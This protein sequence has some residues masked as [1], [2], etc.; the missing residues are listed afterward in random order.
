MT[1]SEML[2]QE[3]LDLMTDNDVI[4]ADNAE[5]MKE[6]TD[7]I[8]RE[9]TYLEHL[10]ALQKQAVTTP[11][12]WNG[13]NVI[14]QGATSAGKTLTAEFAMAYQIYCRQKKVLYLVPLKTLTSEKL[15]DFKADFNGLRI[16]SSS[17]DYQEHDY[18]LIHGDY[19]IGILVYEKFF[20]LLAQN[21]K[22]FLRD[23]ELVVVDELH[24]L[25]DIDRGPKLEFSIEKLRYAYGDS[26]SV[27]GLTTTESDISD[28][29]TWLGKERT[30]VIRNEERPVEIEERFIAWDEENEKLYLRRYN[31]GVQLEDNC[32]FRFSKDINDNSDA[33]LTMLLNIVRNH[34]EEKIIIFCKSKSYGTQLLN[35]LCTSGVLERQALEFDD[36]PEADECEMEQKQYDDFRRKLQE[37]GIVCHNSNLTF[38]ARSFIENNFDDGDIRIIIATETLTMGVNLPTDVMILYDDKVYR[39]DGEVEITYH[40]YKNAIGRAGRLGKNKNGR[41]TSYM[42]FDTEKKMAMKEDEFI[43]KRRMKRIDSSLKKDLRFTGITNKKYLNS[44]NF[45]MAIA[46]YYL[47]ILNKSA[48]TQSDLSV[49]IKTGFTKPDDH[50][51]CAEEV[52]NALKGYN[53]AQKQVFPQLIIEKST[54]YNLFDDNDETECAVNSIGKAFSGFALCEQ[55]LRYICLFFL[56]LPKSDNDK[57]LPKYTDANNFTILAPQQFE[58]ASNN[59]EDAVPDY[60]FDVM[61][62]ICNMNEITKNTA[63]VSPD[64]NSNSDIYRNIRSA[65]LRF[66][67]SRNIEKQFL[68]S[69]VWKEAFSSFNG[70]IPVDQLLAMYRTIVLY[71]WITGRTVVEMRKLLDLPDSEKYFIYTPEVQSLGD[72]CAHLLEAVSRGFRVRNADDYEHSNHMADCFYSLSIRIKYGMSLDLARIANKHIRSLPR[73]KLLKLEKKSAELGYASVTGLIFQCPSET[74]KIISAA[75]RKELME[76]LI[77]PLKFEYDK[78]LDSLE[79]D[80]RITTD[81]IETWEEFVAFGTKASL[82]LLEVLN[83]LGLEVSR[84]R[85]ALSLKKFGITLHLCRSD[86][87]YSDS[88]EVLGSE[89]IN[90]NDGN[91]HIAIYKNGELSDMESNRTCISLKEFRLLVLRCISITEDMTCAGNGLARALERF[92]EIGSAVFAADKLNDICQDIE[93][94]PESDTSIVAAKAGSGDIASVL[95]QYPDILS[96]Q[97]AVVVV[98]GDLNLTQV[99]GDNAHV[100]DSITVNNFGADAIREIMT[101]MNRIDAAAYDTDELETIEA[102]YFIKTEEEIANRLPDIPSG[103]IESISADITKDFPDLF[104]NHAALEVRD[105]IL[106]AEYLQNVM[107]EFPEFNDFAPAGILYAKALEHYMKVRVLGTLRTAFPDFESGVRNPESRKNYLLEEVPDDKITIGKFISIIKSKLDH[108][109]EWADIRKLLAQANELRNKKCAHS[110][111]RLHKEELTELRRASL[112]VI[113]TTRELPE[114]TPRP[115]EK[116]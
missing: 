77:E 111:N 81:F 114:I 101:A 82:H 4:T 66:I 22:K 112:T 100:G 84:S 38:I 94:K 72:I 3:F 1:N 106:Q 71:Y 86:T 28:I 51:N 99:H 53:P 58:D 67:K 90:T 73:T 98:Q 23:C 55:T 49:L 13:N 91:R 62:H 50:D 116:P 26:I 5:L 68:P 74:L 36:M 7:N 11:G 25:S 35:K 21:S 107:S 33:R 20:A 63:Y 31:N 92:T 45:G 9:H 44:M 42:L 19:D 17:S 88:A 96:Q 80:S 70:E 15:S 76:I 10:T 56:Q 103:S 97:P 24:M 29:V 54:D 47:N 104:N 8:T 60:F 37:Y 40:D 83:E 65:V 102:E 2:Y 57:V 78:L 34:P 61:F 14:V 93:I 46:P 109:P 59:T 105:T 30:I 32:D 95:S 27:M 48:F 75:Q 16:Y 64:L 52:I 39:T 41:G 12:F 89:S 18:D 85:D 113:D 110:G 108:I 115:S 79:K 6:F 43:K 69:S 87:E